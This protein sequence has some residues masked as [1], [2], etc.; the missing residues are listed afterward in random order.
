MLPET[1]K[2]L[3]QQQY[4]SFLIKLDT[5]HSGFVELWRI[6]VFVVM[7]NFNVPTFKELQEYFNEL[8][9]YGTQNQVPQEKIVKTHSW[10]D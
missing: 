6:F 7:S 4:E 5:Q 8:T 3:T 1:W 10:F 2:S 9:Q